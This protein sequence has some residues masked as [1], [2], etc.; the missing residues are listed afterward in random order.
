MIHLIE[1]LIPIYF[2]ICNSLFN[3]LFIMQKYLATID[4]REGEEREGEGEREGEKREGE[5]TEGNRGGLGE[6]RRR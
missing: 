2:Y 3:S 1:I 4:R 6:G 5:E